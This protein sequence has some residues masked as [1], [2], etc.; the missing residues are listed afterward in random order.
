[1]KRRSGEDPLDT[2]DEQDYIKEEYEEV[3]FD[4]DENLF[5]SSGNDWLKIVGG[6][7]LCLYIFSYFSLIFL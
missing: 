4:F 2:D 1:M 3:E 7:F 6:T 5:R